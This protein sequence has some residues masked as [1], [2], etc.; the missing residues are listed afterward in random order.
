MHKP[1]GRP[2]TTHLKSLLTPGGCHAE[3]APLLPEG[4]LHTHTDIKPRPSPGG[5][6][7][8]LEALLRGAPHLAVLDM[9]YNQLGPL[10]G[11]VRMY[12][13]LFILSP[14]ASWSFVAFGALPR[15][16]AGERWWA[17]RA[18]PQRAARVG[19]PL[20]RDAH[21]HSLDFS[22]TYGCIENTTN[23]LCDCWAVLGSA[24]QGWTRASCD[25]VLMPA[26]A[27]GR[28]N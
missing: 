4:A 13:A 2:H 24:E 23:T 27:P 18:P 15:V 22:V 20:R 9:S 26:R 16:D 14:L 12:T 8:Q 1:G 5:C 10:C 19:T 3:L 17:A 11:A 21:H 6:R 25:R 28:L 7:A